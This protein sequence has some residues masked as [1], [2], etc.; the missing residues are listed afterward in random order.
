MK[1]FVERRICDLRGC[2]FRRNKMPDMSLFFLDLLPAEP[3]RPLRFDVLERYPSQGTL[4]SIP[5]NAKAV[6][7]F[8]T[9]W[10]FPGRGRLSMKQRQERRLFCWDLTRDCGC[11]VRCGRVVHGGADERRR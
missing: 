7:A 6:E 10:E 2:K 5:L 8:E 3:A 11:E 4:K 9:S 1:W